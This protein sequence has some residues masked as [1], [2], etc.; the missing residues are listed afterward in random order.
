MKHFFPLLFVLST[1]PFPSEV[2]GVSEVTVIYNGTASKVRER[3]SGQ[4]DLWVTL[5]TLT[6]ISGFVLKPQG[7]CLNELCIPIPK[8]RK[9]AFLHKER[10][11]DWFNLSELARV[12]H[13]PAVHDP[14]NSVWAFGAW[15]EAQMKPLKTLEAPNFTLP[16]WKGI[17]RS[18]TD[19]RGKKVLLITWASW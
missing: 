8:A 11:N 3:L 4:E 5:P 6:Q 7:A 18:L 17:R 19:F 1:L 12:L 2:L 9:K 10:G 13:Q 14:P 16:D 15:P